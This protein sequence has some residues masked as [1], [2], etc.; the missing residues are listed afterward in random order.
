MVIRH[1]H[2]VTAG[3]FDVP[4]PSPYMLRCP[5]PTASHSLR[6]PEDEGPDKSHS[7]YAHGATCSEG[8]G[9]V[10][11]VF[12]DNGAPFERD[13]GYSKL[14]AYATLRCDGDEDAAKAELGLAGGRSVDLT[15]LGVN[16]D[17]VDVWDDPLL[18]KV[19]EL[20]DSLAIGRIAVVDLFLSTVGAYVSPIVVMG[21]GRLGEGSLNTL[22]VLVAESGV[23]KSSTMRAV[24]STVGYVPVTEDGR[25]G[26][27]LIVPELCEETWTGE[28]QAR[29]LKRPVNEENDEPEGYRSVIHR[30][31]E[32]SALLAKAEGASS[33]VMVNLTKS[34]TADGMGS[35]RASEKDSY[36]VPAHSYR[37]T[38]QLAGQPKIVLPLFDDDALAMGATGRMMVASMDI[39]DEFADELDRREAAGELDDEV[40]VPVLVTLD[41]A[42]IRELCTEY[43]SGRLHYAT[44]PGIVR[45]LARQKRN[46]NR[47]SALKKRRESATGAAEG[48][49]GLL[50]RKYATLLAIAKGEPVGW[51]HW[52]IAA[53]LVAESQAAMTYWRADAT[54]TRR[55]AKVNAAVEDRDVEREAAKRD[56]EKLAVKVVKWY[57]RKYGATGERVKWS[58]TYRNPLKPKAC[59]PYRDEVRD[60]LAGGFDDRVTVVETAKG[61]EIGPA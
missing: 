52:N 9:D 55:K 25:P 18:A 4:V 35:A 17:E 38:V 19:G 23:G 6:T 33:T 3:S 8:I 2:P 32:A 54:E 53:V 46:R 58:Q 61:Y 10:L 60:L 28:G 59:E 29:M 16:F 7:A 24:D 45:M 56:P 5:T 47:R 15:H 12:S 43:V 48:H 37:D 44:E 30:Q 51:Y 57:L 27:L 41:S 13:R 39:S 21:G 22:T 36:A 14:Q 50:T 20:A 26:E 34:V 11:V 42:A 40:E 1:L 31:G 49:L